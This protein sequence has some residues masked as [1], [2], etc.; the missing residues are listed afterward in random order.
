[1][2]SGSNRFNRSQTPLLS[3]ITA[4]A[5]LSAGCGTVGRTTVDIGRPPAVSVSDIDGPYYVIDAVAVGDAKTATSELLHEACQRR[6]PELFTR[7]RKAVPLLVLR[8]SEVVHTERRKFHWWYLLD[9]CTLCLWPTLPMTGV[10]HDCVRLGSVDPDAPS[11]SF[12][13]K[14]TVYVHTPLTILFD[15]VL[16]PKEE[17]WGDPTSDEFHPY[18]QV[19]ETRQ[20]AFADAIVQT[21]LTMSKEQRMALRSDP[22]TMAA[23]F[24][25]RPYVIG[26]DLPPMF[27]KT[28]HEIPIVRQAA[29]GK[30]PDVTDFQFDP[31]TRRGRI[32]ANLSG[33]DALFAQKW[34][35]YHVLPQKLREA[36]S[37]P[38]ERMIIVQSEDLSRE[39]LYEI[40]FSVIE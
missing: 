25:L 9:A 12:E 10:I 3:A 33:C 34:V 32:G 20:A 27:G 36:V 8:K 2:S 24:R 29:D 16:F 22:K 18:V 7:N 31:G 23:Y 1:M 17:G 15:P 28:I 40:A 35:L 14:E 26:E 30:L 11:T 38:G 6:Y 13:A 21:L 37:L 19:N 4:C 5:L 39:G